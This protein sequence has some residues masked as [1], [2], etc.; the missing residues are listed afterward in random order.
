MAVRLFSNYLYNGNDFIDC[1]QGIATSIEDLKNWFDET[2][3]KDDGG[4]IYIPS[5]FEVRVNDLWYT[6]EPKKEWRP[7]SGYFHPRLTEDIVK[8][9][10]PSDNIKVSEV[11]DTIEI[12]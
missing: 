10:L 6:Y 12:N 8:N 5:G 9:L 4:I 3:H 11:L 2:K 7:D 1:R